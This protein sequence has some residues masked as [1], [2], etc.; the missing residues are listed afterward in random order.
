MP[1]EFDFKSMYEQ[2]DQI[3]QALQMIYHNVVEE[4]MPN[5]V[6][7]GTIPGIFQQLWQMHHYVRITPEEEKL[8]GQYFERHQEASSIFDRD[9]SRL[10]GKQTT[11]EQ[12]PQDEVH[13]LALETHKEIANLETEIL[14]TRIWDRLLLRQRIYGMVEKY[15]I[16]C[17][18]KYSGEK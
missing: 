18:R 16:V 6:F 8:L 3:E 17:D 15:K 13:N 5:I 12:L 9:I 10:R 14:N 1:E 2:L 7:S 11:Q 4:C